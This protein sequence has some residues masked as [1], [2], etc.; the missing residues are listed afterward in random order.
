[1]FAPADSSKASTNFH[2]GLSQPYQSVFCDE[3]EIAASMR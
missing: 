2:A 1:M 3:C